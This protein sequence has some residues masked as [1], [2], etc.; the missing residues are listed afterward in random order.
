[1]SFGTDNR[2]RTLLKSVIDTSIFQRLRR[3]S[4]L[5]LA[6]NVFPGATH[7]RF[8]HGLGAAYLALKALAH[9]AERHDPTRVADARLEVVAAALLH[10]VGHGPFSHSFEQVLAGLGFATSPPLHE[11]WTRAAIELEDSDVRR[12]LADSG[13]DI[14]KVATAFQSD[15]DN[16]PLPK[17]LRQVVSSQIDVDRMDYLVRDSHFAGVALGRVDIYYLIH[18]LT[19]IEHDGGLISS[20]GVEE[21]GV[22]AYEGFALARQLMNRTVYYHRAVKV[23]EFM[24]EEL[25]RLV[26]SSLPVLNRDPELRSAIPR[27]FAAVSA[28]RDSSVR[29]PEDFVAAHWRDYFALSEPDVWHLVQ[30]LATTASA[31]VPKQIKMLAE[32]ILK[33]EKLPYWLVLPG[34]D[35][36][37]RE[38][39]LSDGFKLGED[40][41][42][43]DL[44]TTVYK[45]SKDQVFVEHR[46]GRVVEM[47][48]ASEILAILRDREERASLLIALDPDKGSVIRESGIKVQSIPADDA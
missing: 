45:Q 31:T 33:R 21:K 1:M 20:L 30:R 22:K 41:A 42:L 34:M 8:S 27:Y 10:D 4:Q 2:L 23:F 5:G 26:I 7:T 43:I 32:M 18:C 37:L 16:G 40:Y 39:L 46:G 3:I 25:L 44:R 29:S 28:L 6:Q 11:Q 19:I 15:P 24:M 13:L 17:Y 48:A 47:A 35:Q 38:K 36:V 12:A 9:L 14:A